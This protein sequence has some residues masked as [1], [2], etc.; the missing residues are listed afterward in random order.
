MYSVRH[1]N[2]CVDLPS[3]FFFLFFFPVVPKE[4][5]NLEYYSF[6]HEIGKS[7]CFVHLSDVNGLVTLS[8]DVVVFFLK[9]FTHFKKLPV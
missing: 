9:F 4:K 8:I 3:S 5:V 7:S 6:H 1:R 2:Y